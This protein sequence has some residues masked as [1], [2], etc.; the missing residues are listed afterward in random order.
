M[1]Y[2]SAKAQMHAYAY[3]IT[4]DGSMDMG[5]HLADLEFRQ[6]GINNCEQ[7]CERTTSSR[8]LPLL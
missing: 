3:T 5:P 8:G 6:D 2:G 1:E 7:R 4:I